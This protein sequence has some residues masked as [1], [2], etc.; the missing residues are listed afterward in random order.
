MSALWPASCLRLNCGCCPSQSAYQLCESFSHGACTE[1]WV[2][3]WAGLPAMEFHLSHPGQRWAFCCKWRCYVARNSIQLTSHFCWTKFPTK[4]RS[5]KRNFQ[6]CPEMFSALLAGRKV[7]PQNFTRF[8]NIRSLKFTQYFHNTLLQAWLPQH[9][10]LEFGDMSP[11]FHHTIVAESVVWRIT[12]SVRG[13]KKF[14]V[15]APANLPPPPPKKWEEF[16][17]QYE[18]T[19]GVPDNGNEWRKFRAVPRLYPLCSLVFYIVW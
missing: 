2:T 16:H 7:S 8:L 18:W 10:V 5:L 6:H 13:V 14:D 11:P 19:T 15:F 4:A 17:A 9:T 3:C 12:L 1:Q